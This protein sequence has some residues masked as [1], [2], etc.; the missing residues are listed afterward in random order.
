MPSTPAR[1]DRVE[2][3][4][5]YGYDA[6]WPNWGWTPPGDPSRYYTIVSLSNNYLFKDALGNWVPNGVVLDV[7]VHRHAGI[8]ERGLHPG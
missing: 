3:R 7:P 4:Q 5:Y 1:T 2:R 6:W 8:R